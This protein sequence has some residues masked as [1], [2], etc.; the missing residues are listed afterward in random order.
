MGSRFN[1]C[2]D[3]RGWVRPLI[4]ADWYDCASGTCRCAHF[5]KYA[6]ICSARFRRSRAQVHP[7]G[8]L[9]GECAHDLRRLH[10]EG[11]PFPLSSY[12]NG[13]FRS[14]VRTISGLPAVGYVENRTSPTTACA[15]AFPDVGVLLLACI[16]VYLHCARKVQVSLLVLKGMSRR[17]D[18]YPP[19]VGSVRV[20][21]SP[22]Q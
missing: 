10:A 2:G 1:P 17:G 22:R 7:S 13:W 11:T 5:S 16:T 20:P 3:A 4:C 15:S 6:P 18:S 12:K 21:A 9:G 8:R 19:G 14:G